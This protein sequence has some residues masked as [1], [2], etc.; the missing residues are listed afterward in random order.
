[1][2]PEATT[3]NTKADK[4]DAEIRELQKKNSNIDA[5]AMK[6]VSSSSP[7]QVGRVGK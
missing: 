7:S 2:E 4:H 6:S 3:V 5:R 1:M